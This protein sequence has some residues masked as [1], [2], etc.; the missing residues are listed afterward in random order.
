MLR[1]CRPHVVNLHQYS[2][3]GPH[4]TNDSLLEI[5]VVHLHRSKQIIFNMKRSFF[6][7]LRCLQINILC[8]MHINRI[9]RYQPVSLMTLNKHA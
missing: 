9:L 8:L 5:M 1:F 7:M 4:M 2:M 3:K 6:T